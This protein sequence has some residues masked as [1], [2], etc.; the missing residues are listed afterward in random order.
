MPQPGDPRV[1]FAA[2]R[3][4]LAWTRT[5]LAL[6]AFGFVIER[7]GLV[8]RLLVPAVASSPRSGMSFW[9]G[10]GFMLLGIS[11]VLLASN[12]YRR[13]VRTLPAQD[14]PPGYRVHT[15][16]FMNLVLALLG[17]GVVVYL[18]SGIH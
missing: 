12:Q 17:I 18:F 13:F 3:T 4:L 10:M 1:L 11:V 9:L 16:I 5:S 15:G 8:V 6:M 7:F 2:E 14:F